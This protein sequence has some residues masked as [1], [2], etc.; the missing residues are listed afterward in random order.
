MSQA[1]GSV[2]VSLMEAFIAERNANGDWDDFIGRNKRQLNVTRVAEYAGLVNR[3]VISGK[4]ANPTVSKLFHEAE[5]MLREQG[6]FKED[7]RTDSEKANDEQKSMG[8][9]IAASRAKVT[10]E[11][12]AALQQ[13]NFDL[14]QKN[15]ELLDKLEKLQAIESYMER[16]GRW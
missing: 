12:N 10:S 6:Y 8:D 11:S 13:E 1:K 14:K 7:T 5:E 4:N 9:A 15:K 16:T 2:N 3:K